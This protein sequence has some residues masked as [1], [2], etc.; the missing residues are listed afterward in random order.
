[1]LKLGLRGLAHLVEEGFQL[2]AIL[3]QQQLLALILIV[4]HSTTD[5]NILR[6]HNLPLLLDFLKDPSKLQH[7]LQLHFPP[8]SHPQQYLPPSALLELPFQAK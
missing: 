6:T 2:E 8:H 5:F 4:M 1:M 3:M 7:L